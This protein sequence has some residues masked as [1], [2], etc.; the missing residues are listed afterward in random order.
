MWITS[1]NH[2]SCKEQFTAVFP[3]RTVW[4]LMDSFSHCLRGKKAFTGHRW[5][6][7]VFPSHSTSLWHSFLILTQNFF[8]GL[9]LMWTEFWG[10]EAENSLRHLLQTWRWISGY[11]SGT[12]RWHPLGVAIDSTG[13]EDFIEMSIIQ[14]YILRYGLVQTWMQGVLGILSVNLKIYLGTI[15]LWMSIILIVK[16]RCYSKSGTLK[17]AVGLITKSLKMNSDYF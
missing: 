16:F 11:A 10:K 9:A 13:F 7:G 4:L 3:W 6:L 1:Q 12:E 15:F 5:R 8:D 17:S 14:I 2:E